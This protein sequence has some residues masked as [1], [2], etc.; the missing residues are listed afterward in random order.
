MKEYSP[1]CNQK[2]YDCLPKSWQEHFVVSENIDVDMMV[3]TG[4]GLIDLAMEEGN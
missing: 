4:A 1:M 2:T 3:H